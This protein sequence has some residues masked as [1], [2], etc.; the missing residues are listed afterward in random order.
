MGL[1]EAAGL[2]PVPS[3]QGRDD[4]AVFDVA[5]GLLFGRGGKEEVVDGRPGQQGSQRLGED[6]V[7]SRSGQEEMEVGDAAEGSRRRRR[8]FF[9]PPE[10]GVQFGQGDGVGMGHGPSDGQEFEVD[11]DLVGPTDF[12]D[13]GVA[14]AGAAAGQQKGDALGGKAFEGLPDRSPADA[15]PLGEGQGGKAFAGTD[16]PLPDEADDGLVGPGVG[17]TV[18]EGH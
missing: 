12:L 2:F 13:G 17:R 4:P 18:V 6:G 16:P 5:G 11:P 15:E 3:F 9:V 10:R 14:K 8:F 1:H 7:A